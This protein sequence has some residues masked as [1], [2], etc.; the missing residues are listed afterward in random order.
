MIDAFDIIAFA[1]FVVLLVIA[2]VLVANVGQLPGQI[3][4]K[5]GHPQAA[6]INVTGWL[7]LV[8]PPLWLIALIWAFLR[9]VAVAAS[10]GKEKELRS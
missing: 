9:P 7:G 8:L 6:A 5:R 4:Q 3:A 10:G 2:V 1:V